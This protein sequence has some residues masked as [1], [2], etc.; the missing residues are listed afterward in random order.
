MAPASTGG[1]LQPP[2]LLVGRSVSL[3][4]VFSALGRRRRLWLCSAA[5]GLLAGLGYHAV[6]PRSYTASSTLYLAHAP[7]TDDGVDMAN[8]LAL[9]QTNAV[10]QRAIGLLHEPSLT[11][12]QLLGQA[13]GTAQSENVLTLDVSGPTKAEAVKRVNA[14][15]DAFLR[16]RSLQAR[17]Q[18]AATNAALGGQ[19]S[20]LEQDI[21]TVTARI[22]TLGPSSTGPELS[23]LV[24]QQSSDSSQMSALTQEVNQNWLAAD[25]IQNGSSVLTPGMPVHDSTLKLFGENGVSGLVGGLLAGMGFVVIQEV[26]SDRVRRRD[27]VASLLGVTVDLSL[28]PFRHPR[29]RIVRWIRR[30]EDE[31]VEQVGTLARYLRRRGVP[32]KETTTLL[33]L[34]ADETAI[35]AA[36]LALLATRLAAEG[37]A[38]TVV[39]LTSDRF[40]MHSLSAKASDCVEPVGGSLSVVVPSG[41]EPDGNLDPAWLCTS[42]RRAVL[43]LATVDPGSGLWHLSWSKEAVVTVTAGRSSAAHLNTIAALIRTSGISIRS[44]VLL[45]ADSDDETVGV[46]TPGIPLVGL[47]VDANVTP[48]DSP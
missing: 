15:A 26:V 18:A 43:V 35:P 37:K 44:G 42:N 12:Q 11:P 10:G 38:V 14:L 3:R 45:D 30:M 36:S 29:K 32:G 41:D 34:A 16:F 28:P 23:T 24:G 22:D 19:I 4:L 1:E 2:V 46:L 31:P 27:E 7:G 9:L 20:L 48:L 33:V 13:P 40:L 47:P 25:T 6:V 5:V 8:D 21:Q 39:D 17:Q